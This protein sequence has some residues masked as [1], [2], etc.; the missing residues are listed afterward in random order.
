MENF[1]F[2]GITGV[3]HL[4]CSHGPGN[5][6]HSFAH[7]GKHPT[8]NPQPPPQMKSLTTETAYHIYFRMSSDVPEDM[9]PSRDVN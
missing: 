8:T 3:N 4:L 9:L 7:L 1:H 6:T 2:A 5:R